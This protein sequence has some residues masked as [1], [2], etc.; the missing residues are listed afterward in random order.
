[1]GQETVMNRDMRRN[2]RASLNTTVVVQG[3][4]R[5][6]KSF[7]IQGEGVDFSRKGL[8]LLIAE[9]VVVPGSVVAISIPNRLRTDAVVEWT[10]HDAETGKIRI[11]VR[12]INPQVRT[13]IRIAAAFLLCLAL[14]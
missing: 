4:D 1:M 12:M 11:G 9:N 6:G 7:Q 3:T 10:R 2:I 14:L 8:G 5:F 13:G